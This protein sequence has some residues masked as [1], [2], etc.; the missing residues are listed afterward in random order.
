MS[1]EDEKALKMRLA[2][3]I[4]ELSALERAMLVNMPV[5]KSSS[6]ATD[7]ARYSRARALR[8]ALTTALEE[9]V[10]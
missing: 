7:W 1:E 4:E 9:F 10:S 2:A 6:R 5:T 3:L 8:G